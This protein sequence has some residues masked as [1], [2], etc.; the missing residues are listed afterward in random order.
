MFNFFKLL[1]LA[2]TL[3]FPQMS[4]AE[5]CD[6]TH[7][8]RSMYTNMN[9]AYHQGGRA[10]TEEA[11]TMLRAAHGLQPTRILNELS[12]SELGSRARFAVRPLYDLRNAGMTQVGDI[13]VLSGLDRAV[14][15][16]GVLRALNVLSALDCP[17]PEAENTQETPADTANTDTLWDPTI[18]GG[19]GATMR[20][21]AVGAI[22]VTLGVSLAMSIVFFERRTKLRKRFSCSLPVKFRGGPANWQNARAL[23]ISREGVK[24]SV[25]GSDTPPIGTVFSVQIGDAK[26]SGRVHWAKPQLV[27]ARFDR[28]LTEAEIATLLKLSRAEVHK[29]SALYKAEQRAAQ[30]AA[31]TKSGAQPSAA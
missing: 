11:L 13:V 31:E 24:L 9:L 23:D 5:V 7:Q 20:Y 16:R 1:T 25:P 30:M 27:G 21:G 28:S 15:N 12:K 14:V 8:L 22:V 19:S 3:I 26:I 17:I 10:P 6:T 4:R 29:Q 18:S 2:I